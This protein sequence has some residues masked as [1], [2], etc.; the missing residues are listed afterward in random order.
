MTR[1]PYF[2]MMIDLQGKSVLVVGG[3]LVAS[4]RAE[5]LNDVRYQRG[6]N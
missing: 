2:P 3:G 5:T 6:R 1:P 4:R